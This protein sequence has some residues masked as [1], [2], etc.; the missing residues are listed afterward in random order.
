MQDLLPSTLLIQN[1]TICSREFDGETVMMDE[2][3]ENYFG[4]DEIGT[5][6]WQ[7]LKEKHSL[8]ELCQ[9]LTKEYEVEPEQCLAD[10]TPFIEQLIKDNMLVT[11]K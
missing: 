6:V 11:V 5:R 9:K 3:L 10:I 2:N 7:I 8:T 4:L 1:H